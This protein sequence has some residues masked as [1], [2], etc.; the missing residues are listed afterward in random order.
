MQRDAELARVTRAFQCGTRDKTNQ[1]RTMTQALRLCASL[2]VTDFLGLKG[3]ELSTATSFRIDSI[4][5]SDEK[6]ELKHLF[7]AGMVGKAPS[8]SQSLQRKLTVTIPADAL[9]PAGRFR[10]TSTSL[11]IDLYDAMRRARLQGRRTKRTRGEEQDTEAQPA[12]FTPAEWCTNVLDNLRR[13][14]LLC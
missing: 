7:S 9:Y 3:T 13:T 11:D 4:L 5:N 2:G 14:L 8:P 10:T 12:D 1:T 6:A